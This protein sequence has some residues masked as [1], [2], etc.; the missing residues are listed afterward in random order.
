MTDSFLDSMDLNLR[1]RRCSSLVAIATAGTVITTAAI[2]AIAVAAVDNVEAH[3]VATRPRAVRT[4]TSS[5][6][7]DGPACF[8]RSG[9]SWDPSVPPTLPPDP[10]GLGRRPSSSRPA[11]PQSSALSKKRLIEASCEPQGERLG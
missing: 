8:L 2:I 5:A 1:R 11:R 10:L 3:L 4:S 9:L 6:E 7:P